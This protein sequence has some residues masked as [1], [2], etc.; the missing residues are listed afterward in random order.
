VF[1]RAWFG[2]VASIGVKKNVFR[3]L[4]RKP[5]KR[6]MKRLEVLGVYKKR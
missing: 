5:K 2:R 3:V 6:K 1:D 4:L